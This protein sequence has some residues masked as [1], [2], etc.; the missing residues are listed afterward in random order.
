M[1]VLVVSVHPDDETLGCGGTLLKH[2]ARGDSLH[3]LLITSAHRQDFPEE[4][5]KRQ[6]KQVAA[7]QQAYPF[8]TLDWL[9]QPAA[10]LET[11]PLNALV[12]GIAEAVERVEPEVVFMPNPGDVHS[13]HRV[14]FAAAMSVLR[15]LYMRWRGVRRVVACEVPSETD[16]APMLGRPDFVP[17]I[18]T[19]ISDTLERKLEIMALYQ[20]ELQPDP[21]PRSLSAIRALAG[22]RGA[23]IGVRYAEAFS[24][25]REL[26]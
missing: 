16:A 8:A 12:K 7:V 1:K 21:L 22:H 18:F 23:T 13:D 6:E 14:V 10:R 5:I 20:S 25:I 15:P 9:R 11:V 19:D 2:A 17:N 3:W 26:I 24:L 4:A